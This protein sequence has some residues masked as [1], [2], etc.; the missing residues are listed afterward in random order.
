MTLATKHWLNESLLAG[1]VAPRGELRGSEGG[2][3]L[4]WVTESDR[5]FPF[6]YRKMSAERRFLNEECRTVRLIE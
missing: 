3:R 4:P 6:G 1:A 5:G 2:V